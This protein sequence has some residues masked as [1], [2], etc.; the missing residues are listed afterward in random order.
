M[1]N[2]YYQQ[3]GAQSLGFGISPSLALFEKKIQSS[4]PLISLGCAHPAKFPE[5]IIK[6]VNFKPKN[7]EF[8]EQILMSSENFDKLNNE[9]NVIKDYIYKEMRNKNAY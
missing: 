9:I 7:P 2:K 3:E 6:S 5:T 1:P 8:L 4:T